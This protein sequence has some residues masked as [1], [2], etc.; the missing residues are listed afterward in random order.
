MNRLDKKVEQP[1]RAPTSEHLEEFGNDGLRTLAIAYREVDAEF[2][3]NWE[4]RWVE[5]EKMIGQRE[6]VEK[7]RDLLAE[8]IEVDLTLLG[9]TALE[10]VFHFYIFLHFS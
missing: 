5:L 7:E 2:H 10:D 6:K 1:L 9:A 4:K 3:S 8:E